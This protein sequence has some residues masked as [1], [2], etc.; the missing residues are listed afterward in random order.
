MTLTEFLLARIA[1][2]KASASTHAY[3]TVVGDVALGD[4]RR[5]PLNSWV[6]FNP[7]RVLAE[8][9]AKRR[10][11]TEVHYDRNAE[12]VA[13]AKADHERHGWPVLV[14]S[15]CASCS[16]YSDCVV[17]IEDCP[18]LRLLALPYVDH[19][20]FQDEWRA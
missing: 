16:C 12:S 7:A 3:S 1:E 13:E 9:E 8:C 17:S 6:R 4:G 11:V 18:T 5:A 10:I 19:P 14:E 2:D 15:E 20:S